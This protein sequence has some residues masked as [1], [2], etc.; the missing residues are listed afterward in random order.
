ML[1]HAKVRILRKLCAMVGS[2]HPGQDDGSLLARGMRLNYL[3]TCNLFAL[4]T[5][6]VRV[7]RSVPL[8]NPLVPMLG[9]IFCAWGSFILTLKFL[10]KDGEM[11]RMGW[12]VIL[13]HRTRGAGTGSQLT[14]RLVSDHSAPATFGLMF[15]FAI[16]GLPMAMSGPAPASADTARRAI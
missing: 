14:V 5:P 3:V 9:N 13:L 16:T 10:S 6:R 2:R 12:Q 7:A 8:K 11:V 1:I 15:D 4:G